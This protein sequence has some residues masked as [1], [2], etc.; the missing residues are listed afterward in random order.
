M[1]EAEAKDLQKDDHVSVS[2]PL[3]SEALQKVTKRTANI[4]VVELEFE[5]DAVVTAFMPTILTKGASL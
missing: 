4:Q 3:G 1:A 5:G 2:T